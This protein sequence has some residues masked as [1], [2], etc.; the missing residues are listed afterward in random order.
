MNARMEHLLKESNRVLP[1]FSTTEHLFWCGSFS[2]EPLLGP[3]GA[4]DV[5]ESVVPLVT[6]ELI[7]LSLTLGSE[8]LPSTAWSTLLHHKP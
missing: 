7:D 6:G 5:H 8:R 3:S 4:E 1:A 2:R